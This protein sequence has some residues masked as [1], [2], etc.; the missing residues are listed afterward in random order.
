MQGV[1]VEIN[2]VKRP[3]LALAGVLVT[4]LASPAL[5]E[6][7]VVGPER[8]TNEQSACRQF[9]GEPRDA[10]SVAFRWQQRLSL[11]AC[12]EEVTVARIPKGDGRAI[13]ALVAQLEHGFAASIAIYD[14]AMATGPAYVRILG[15][16]G[17]GMAYLAI[18]VRARAALEPEDVVGRRALERLLDRDERAAR[19]AFDEVGFLADDYPKA[20]HDNPV[21]EL[22]VRNARTEAERLR[23]EPAREMLSWKP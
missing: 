19:A 21:V 6:R 17:L 9:I 7:L 16:Y 4:T 11:A 5:A 22:A 14:D 20:T 3:T 23:G 8:E 13:R 1:S 2:M 10:I 15:A 12:R 18:I